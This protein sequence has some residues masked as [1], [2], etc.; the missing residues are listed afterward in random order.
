[1]F[2]LK[3][4]ILVIAPG[5]MVGNSIIPGPG[6]PRRMV[7]H[8]NVSIDPG[9]KQTYIK[10]AKI[11]PIAIVT[12]TAEPKFE[13]DFSDGPELW[14]AR[15]AL[16]GINSPIIVSLTFARTGMTPTSF[17]V[18][19]TWSNGGGLALDESN[20]SKPDKLSVMCLDVLQDLRSIYNPFS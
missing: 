8:T 7:S 10:G 6:T 12:A 2:S 15:N 18:P 19:G 20:G 1:M 14:S 16:G 4:S 13:I 17:S 3:D 11:L 9:G 5:L